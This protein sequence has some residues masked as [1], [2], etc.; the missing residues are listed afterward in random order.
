MD[1]WA[2]GPTD[3]KTGSKG[4]FTSHNQSVE[5]PRTFRLAPQDI[6]RRYYEFCSKK[7]V[8]ILF[9]KSVMKLPGQKIILTK[10]NDFANTA[11]QFGQ[12]KWKV[13]SAPMDQRTN[14]W[15]NGATN[16]QTG[17]KESFTSSNHSVD[18]TRTILG[19]Y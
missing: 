19:D 16:W 1:Q 9:C 15:T 12:W 7:R 4:S 17:L 2:N 10:I 14:Q 3:R 8:L 5:D 11:I 13:T 18:D 6:H